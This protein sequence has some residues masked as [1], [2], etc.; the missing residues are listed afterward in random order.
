MTTLLSGRVSDLIGRERLYL[1]GPVATGVLG[2]VYF[3]MM[4]TALPGLIFLASIGFH[5]ASIIAG[6]PAPLIGTAL[7]AA[8]GSG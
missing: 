8:T 2:F 6:G 3:A 4:N 5:L 7:F 1:I